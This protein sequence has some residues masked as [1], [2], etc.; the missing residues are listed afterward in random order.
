MRGF[1]CCCCCYLA[2]LTLSSSE[3]QQPACRFFFFLSSFP[4]LS[5]FLFLLPFL[6]C[7]NFNWTCC[8][9]CC[10]RWCQWR[11]QTCFYFGQI[12]H[13]FPTRLAARGQLAAL[14]W[15]SNFCFTVLA[16]TYLLACWCDLSYQRLITG[17][18]RWRCRWL[19]VLA[20]QFES[21]ALRTS[22]F[23]RKSQ[24]LFVVCAKSKEINR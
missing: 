12:W 19:L 16:L 22:P 17:R 15:A 6:S 20:S 8:C 13:S 24:P 4:S 2:R 21:R 5:L 10:C 9:C 14:P 23:G 1:G 18:G 7:C 11:W 3:K